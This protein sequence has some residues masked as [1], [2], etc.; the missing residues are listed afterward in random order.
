M[1]PS[2]VAVLR[3]ISSSNFVGALHLEVGRLRTS[4]NAIGV[5]CHRPEGFE[6]IW[7]IASLFNHLIGAH[8]Q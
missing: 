7:A 8:K 4:K 6:I 5:T 2:A 3:L 1:R